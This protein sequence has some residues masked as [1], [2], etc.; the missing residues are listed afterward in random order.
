VL[1]KLIPDPETGEPMEFLVTERDVTLREHRAEE[2]QYAKEVAEAAMAEAKQ[3]SEAKTAFLATMS[4]EI[5]TPLNGV[6]GYTDLLLRSVGLS[7]TNRR[8]AERIGTSGA[9]L[10]TVVNDILD[11]SRIEAGKIELDPHPFSL[12]ELVDN[13]MAI[14]GGTAARKGLHIAADVEPDL[15]S[16]MLGD[17]NRLRQILLNLLNNAVKFTARGSVRLSVKRLQDGDK[18]RYRFVVRD[19]G[20]GI[21]P[22]QRNRLFERF[23]Q[24][25][26]TVRR[27]FGGSGLGLAISRRLVEVMGGSIGVDS[28]AGAG[29]AF[30]FEVVLP[31][32]N[33]AVVASLGS[34]VAETFRPARILLVEDMEINQDIACAV[35]SAAGHQVDLATDG[36][37][38]VAAVQVKTYDVVL[39]D[40]Q[41][42]G[43]DGL[44]ATRR[45]RELT[46]RARAVPIVALTANVL[47]FQIAELHAAGMCDHVGKP[48]RR[49]DLL[50]AVDRAFRGLN[51]E[52]SAESRAI[53]SDG[54]GETFSQLVYVDLE[55]A[56]GSPGVQRLLGK[57]SAG[58]RVRLTGGWVKPDER[59]L[60]RR[61]AHML[62]SSTGMIGFTRLSRIC[63]EIETA[64]DGGGDLTALLAR[65]A[66]VREAALDKIETLKAAA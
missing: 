3:A 37:E 12:V 25:D 53:G 50:A 47:P 11:F 27:Q 54:E 36:A 6:I 20:I 31:E 61:D 15:P 58:L 33:E 32:T 8:Y 4:H 28:E 21:P 45:I 59:E 46:T 60:L 10:L 5:R 38:A 34:A 56:I 40:I 35:L 2:L 66:K 29:S 44:T 1:W 26:G 48:F 7:E 16:R 39:M 65:Y 49:Y 14:V 42:P 24:V 13:A 57:L 63:R 51:E 64:C 62:I 41:M 18:A 52:H 43:M 55:A 30:W 23:S 17:E 9:A 22:E 19:T